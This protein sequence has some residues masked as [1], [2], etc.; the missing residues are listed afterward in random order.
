MKMLHYIVVA[1]ALVC[2]APRLATSQTVM[3]RENFAQQ[4]FGDLGFIPRA[5]SR[6]GA[7]NSVQVMDLA[8]VQCIVLPRQQT[9]WF[10]I[11]HVD[12]D[13]DRVGYF[14][15]KIF[16]HKQTN[17][18]VAYDSLRLYRNDG[19]IG[20]NGEKLG[21]F[22]RTRAGART[23][24]ALHDDTM[25]QSGDA[26]ARLS[27]LEGQA[28]GQFHAR[29]DLNSPS[30]WDDRRIF[31]DRDAA[32]LSSAEN[33]VLGARLFRFSST[34]KLFTDSPMDFDFNPPPDIDSF[35]VDISSPG[36]EVDHQQTRINIRAPCGGTLSVKK[37]LFGSL[38]GLR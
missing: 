1:G 13:N 2:V 18:T 11:N 9:Y 27:L 22:F 4:A 12:A 31:V 16:G 14:A 32:T 34:K 25:Q 28:S 35:V 7:A 23:F 8:G 17:A 36:S 20:R 3:H 10:R 21:A 24:S 26:G 6:D 29:P 37:S 33:V 38:F 15:V 30:S 5:Q 19:W